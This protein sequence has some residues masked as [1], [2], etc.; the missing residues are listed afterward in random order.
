MIL[1][2]RK[3]ELSS[4]S[5]IISQ[6]KNG[7]RNV[8]KGLH[9]LVT[10]DTEFENREFIVHTFNLISPRRRECAIQLLYLSRVKIMKNL[11]GIA[12]YLQSFFPRES[13]ILNLFFTR[14]EGFNFI[15]SVVCL[16]TGP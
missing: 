11:K 1:D 12:K 5:L 6:T 3:L 9:Y 13:R 7:E 4:E 16:T 2:I 14:D 8:E 15:H 10:R